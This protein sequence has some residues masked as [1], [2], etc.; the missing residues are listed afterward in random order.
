MKDLV[1]K[2]KNMNFKQAAIQHVEKMVFA[3]V[4]LLVVLVLAGTSWSRYER[5]PEE[6]LDKIRKGEANLEN[7]QWPEDQRKEFLAAPDV[8]QIVNSFDAGAD[9]SRFE[10]RTPFFWP[11]YP[12][13]EKYKEPQLLA[14]QDLVADPGY[15]I[16]EFSTDATPENVEGEAAAEDG[17]TDAGAAAETSPR[18]RGPA[19]NELAPRDAAG[20]AVAGPD[21]AGRGTMK[22][23]TETTPAGPG[24]TSSKKQMMG[25]EARGLRYVAVRGIF[26]LKEQID[27]I[28]VA[29]NEPVAAEAE[30]YLDFIDFVLE[31][32]TAVAGADAW[33]GP[34]EAVNIQDA[35]DVLN[36]VTDFDV[37]LV[38][39]SL[40]DAV[41]TMPLPYRMAGSW[42]NKV[43]HPKIKTLTLEQAEQ[44]MLINS[45]MLEVYEKMR[46]QQKDPYEKKGFAPRQVDVRDMR[47]DVRDVDAVINAVISELKSSGDYKPFIDKLPN[48]ADPQRLLNGLTSEQV[49][50][51]GRVLLFRYL[52][53]NVEPGN[54]YRYR[55][56]LVLRNPNFQR[57]IAELM[58]PASADGITR[59]TPAS[60]PSPMAFLPK[61]VDVF[62]TRVDQVRGRLETSA[63]FEVYEWYEPSGT[64]IRGELKRLHPGDRVGGTV[65]TEVLRPAEQRFENEP[66]VE[67]S[68]RNVLV[69]IAPSQL[70][71]PEDHPDL[72][73]D[74]RARTGLGLV[75]EVLML[76]NSGSFVCLDTV[77]Q[78]D[79]RKQ[80]QANLDAQNEPWEFLKKRKMA[81]APGPGMEGESYDEYEA[82]MMGSLETEMQQSYD[83]SMSESG[84]GVHDEY[85]SGGYPGS[86][87]P[88]RRRSNPLRLG[89]GARFGPR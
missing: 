65:E 10:Y 73:L 20:N 70:L 86:G 63:E 69:D 49:S 84:M 85:G 87:Y 71:K 60:D 81:S 32:Q 12:K 29:M 78:R 52:D 48:S 5:K 45:K 33:T 42:G 37:D 1:A 68:T 82:N 26:P 80:A 51:S 11:L 28:A 22:L 8:L 16:L 54:A 24:A 59:E 4:V 14:V 47:H 74:P 21:T 40:T 35:Y 15:V 83:E 57:P 66:D 19:P 76:S 3:I 55:V 34:W 88:S 7:S 41:F 6:F 9:L 64:T 30:Q 58:D 67:I 25:V 31:R 62:L 39:S 43:T 44:Q 89:P 13:K 2:L 46:Q 56:R 17:K 79:A 77:S 50:I 38:D 72:Q 18:T 27:K 61:D 23:G 75:D 53:F 36:K